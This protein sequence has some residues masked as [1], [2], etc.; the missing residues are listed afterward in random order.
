MR[1]AGWFTWTAL[2]ALVALAACIRI[3]AALSS[4][5]FDPVHPEGL[6]RSDPGQV[7]Y[8]RDQLLSAEARELAP[9]VWERY[10]DMVQGTR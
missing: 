4:P 7:P 3:Q 10:K 5:A 1:G 2:L 8:V 9:Q 6:L